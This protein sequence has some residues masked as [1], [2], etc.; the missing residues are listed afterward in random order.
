ML[1]FTESK[2]KVISSHFSQNNYESVSSIFT[3]AVWKWKGLRTLAQPLMAKTKLAVVYL[4]LAFRCALQ[5]VFFSVC[6]INFFDDEEAILKHKELW[7]VQGA[8]KKQGRLVVR[9]LSCFI[10]RK[11]DRC[12]FFG[13]NWVVEKPPPHPGR[14]IMLCASRWLP[15]SSKTSI[16]N[17]PDVVITSSGFPLWPCRKGAKFSIAR[18]PHFFSG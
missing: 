11:S 18:P 13:C 14:S 5:C 3:L 2:L 10:M 17:L 1:P 7:A 6:S 9:W 4:K 12:A 16:L 15:Q 8:N